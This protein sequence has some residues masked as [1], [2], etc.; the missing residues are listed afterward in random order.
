MANAEG[1][2]PSAERLAGS[3]P[4]TVTMNVI[5]ICGLCTRARATTSY[6]GVPVCADCKQTLAALGHELEDLERKDPKV[7]RPAWQ[8]DEA[9]KSLS[10]SRL[11]SNTSGMENPWFYTKRLSTGRVT[12]RWID[13]RSDYLPTALL[14][15]D[16]RVCDEMEK[17]N[18]SVYR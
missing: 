9:L 17:R 16:Q 11:P 5:D 6:S 18:G 1:L 7:R 8:V 4:A 12:A 15:L 13:G 10:K 2:N 14:E 3:T